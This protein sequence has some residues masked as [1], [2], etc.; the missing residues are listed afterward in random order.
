M[1]QGCGCRVEVC[2]G[3]HKDKCTSIV[4]CPLHEA[5]GELKRHL[6]EAYAFWVQVKDDLPFKV[7]NEMGARWR[8]ALAASEGR[9]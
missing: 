4:Y 5:A 7:S 3:E 2:E 8:A 9:V 1:S 6:A